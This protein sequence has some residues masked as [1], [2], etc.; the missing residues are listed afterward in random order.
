MHWIGKYYFKYRRYEMIKKAGF[1]I[2]TLIMIIYLVQTVNAQDSEFG[3]Q[4]ISGPDGVVL[5]I[6]KDMLNPNT[7]SQHDGWIGY[8]IYKREM[9]KS[10]FKK[11]NSKPITRA[12]SLADLEKE[13]DLYLEMGVKLLKLSG[14]D[15]L[16][17][18]IENED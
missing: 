13:L 15:E 4:A 14:K 7:A 8:N 9:G 3:V 2:A 18:M 10:K 17:Q 16:W 6:G 12:N 11:I 5:M 1:Y